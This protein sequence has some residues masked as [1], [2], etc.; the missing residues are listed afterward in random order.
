MVVIIALVALFLGFFVVRKNIGPALLAVIAGFS[1]YQMF[2]ADLV[3]FVQNIFT[4]APAD[5]ITHIVYLALI[6]GFPM[7]LYFRSASGGLFGILRIA[8]AAIFAA[9]LTS[10]IAGPLAYFF[11]FDTLSTDIYNFIQSIIGPITIAGI[12]AAYLDILL[13]RE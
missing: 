12:I 5:L 2:G 7:I 8:E 13:Y 9:L 6:L 11:P 10:F 3:R 1:I 4:D